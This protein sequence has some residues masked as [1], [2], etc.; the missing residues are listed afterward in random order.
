M[1]FVTAENVDKAPEAR[2]FPAPRLALRGNPPQLMSE[3]AAR[4]FLAST[5]SLKR[6]RSLP[7]ES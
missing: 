1:P 7:S 5:K 2:A 4:K 3:S 6:F